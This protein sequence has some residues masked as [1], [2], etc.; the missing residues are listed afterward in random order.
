ALCEAAW[1]HCCYLAAT[2]PK[3]HR[4]PRTNGVGGLKIVLAR[5]E[6]DVLPSIVI[7]PAAF[8]KLASMDAT[9]VESCV[10]FTGIE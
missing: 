6:S 10:L 9:I 4:G 7:L 1:L 2:A 8:S 3:M 5:T